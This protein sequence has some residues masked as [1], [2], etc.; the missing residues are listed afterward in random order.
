MVGEKS[1]RQDLLYRLNTVEI[2]L[3]PLKERTEDIAELTRHFMGLYGKKYQ[4]EGLELSGR[5]MKKLKEYHWPGNI[6]ELQHAIERAVIMTEGKFVEPADFQLQES[7]HM[8]SIS[9]KDELNLEEVERIAIKNAVKKHNGNLS[10]AAREL[11]LGRTTLYR[12]MAK[13]EL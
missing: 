9:L 1:F 8:D 4:R 3:P 11:G 10:K 6:R 2:K 13:Y 5:A 12:K 7:L